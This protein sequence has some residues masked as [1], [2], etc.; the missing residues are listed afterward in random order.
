MQLLLHILNQI[1]ILPEST[2]GSGIAALSL[3][4]I[5]ISRH[6]H[7]PK[8]R[9]HANIADWAALGYVIMQLVT[10]TYSHERPN[11]IHFIVPYVPALCLYFAIRL[12]VLWPVASTK[13]IL[14]AAV[15]FGLVLV[16]AN[17]TLQ[18]ESISA[19]NKLFASSELSSVRASLP[20]VGG[21]TRNDGLAM[22]LVTLPFALSGSITKFKAN[23]HFCT[24]SA[25]ASSGLVTVLI[26]GFS[27][28]VYIALLVLLITF[29]VVIIHSEA[30]SFIRLVAVL[31]G[32][33]VF[34]STTV[35]CFKAQR[36]VVD[37]VLA[38]RTIS[39][40]MSTEGR[41]TIWHESISVIA[42]HPLWG[43]SG[44][45][46]G[47]LALKRLNHS[48]LPFTART[49]NAPLDVLTSSGL[50]GFALYG[51]FLLY[52]LWGTVQTL[53]HSAHTPPLSGILAAGIFAAIIRDITYSSL[54]ANGTT[55]VIVWSMVALVQNANSITIPF[56][57]RKVWWATLGP[58]AYIV[59][60]LSCVSIVLSYRLEIAEAHYRMGCAKFA[61]GNYTLA[62]TE[63]G[64][65]IQI[66]PKQPMFYSADGLVAAVEALGA[67]PSPNLWR[68]LPVLTKNEN[69]ILWEAEQDFKTSVRLSGDDSA[70]WSNLG[71]IEAFRGEESEAAESFER[72]IQVDPHDAVSRIGAGLL[73]ERGGF[74]AKAY[75]QYAYAIVALPRI[76]DS[77]FLK[78][79]QARDFV[80]AKAVVVRAANLLKGSPT[81]PVRLASLA[82]LHAFLG[83]EELAHE[84]YA[85]A[86][87]ALPNLSYTCANLGVLDLARGNIDIANR[88]FKRALFLGGGNRLATNM[89]ASVDLANGRVGT[90]EGFYA[91]AILTPETSVHA[92]RTWRLY[93]VPAPIPDDSVP[94]GLLS[95]LSPDIKP[96]EICN[97]EWLTELRNADSDSS[98]VIRRIAAQV[99]FC[100]AH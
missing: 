69:D 87:D 6:Y 47:L 38:A 34:A 15:I 48:N 99:E 29:A 10:L 49:Y 67:F 44:G 93:D 24:V 11:T 100:N 66:E 35:L 88:E 97:E 4:G 17:L 90:A 26:L 59:L 83:E 50:I 33:A 20:L 96:V 39:Q 77:S 52:P 28:S 5:V 79:L 92:E 70:F 3:L 30:V 2:F 95:Y 76:V 57:D 61:S 71:W 56:R 65:A 73:Y 89:L 19:A 60:G 46:D 68:K 37:T 9:D 42:E 12:L 27:R 72:A 31:A 84:E 7:R 85:R 63:F 32:I 13:V 82:K 86:L 58:V 41:L 81:T 22:V 78:D 23:R 75:E 94:P 62:R 55:I 36:P 21:S 1:L 40:Q 45:V 51:I 16:F 80:S 53:T 91:R 54:V 64:E 8:F 74:T 14:R 25:I 18:T 98:D 43:N